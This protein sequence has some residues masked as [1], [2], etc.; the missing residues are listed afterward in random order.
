MSFQTASKING[1]IKHMAVMLIPRDPRLVAVVESLDADEQY[2]ILTSIDKATVNSWKAKGVLTTPYWEALEL[3]E[4]RPISI[5][6]P[7]AT[8]PQP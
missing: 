8:L 4:D 6:I 5:G 1:I 7:S 3:L 2:E